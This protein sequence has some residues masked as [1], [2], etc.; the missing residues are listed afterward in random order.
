MMTLS[1]NYSAILIRALSEICDENDVFAFCRK[2]KFDVEKCYQNA[3][4]IADPGKLLAAL[5]TAKQDIAT[6]QKDGKK[7]LTIFDYH[8]QISNNY[9]YYWGDKNVLFSPK[10]TVNMSHASNVLAQR[11]DEI[12][13]QIAKAI[14]TL[15]KEH[16]EISLVMVG[17]ASS[18]FASCVRFRECNQPVIMTTEKDLGNFRNNVADCIVYDVRPSALKPTP[19]TFDLIS[20][21]STGDVA[22]K[23]L[24]QTIVSVGEREINVTKLGVLAAVQE[25][26]TILLESKN[27]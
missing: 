27:E 18:S 12:L 11:V 4:E 24:R 26:I 8:D 25:I 22:V 10:F 13:E 15:K 23:G 7:I 9:I 21:E 19:V 14:E 5:D 16:P 20:V 17:G 6:K 1:N 2:Y 3:T